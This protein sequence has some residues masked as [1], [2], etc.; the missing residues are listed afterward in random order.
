[1]SIAVIPMSAITDDRLSKTQLRVLLAL[2]SF[3]NPK[4]TNVVFP[5][6]EKLA[7]ITG[8]PVTKISKT[9]SDL[10]KLGWLVKDGNGGRS[11]TT[12]YSLCETVPETVTVTESETVTDLTLNGTRI[13]ILNGTRIGEG[14][15]IDQGIDQNISTGDAKPAR[16]KKVNGQ[17][18]VTQNTPMMARVGSW[19]GRKPETLWTRDEADALRD[20]APDDDELNIVERYYLADHPKDS[21]FR[22]HNVKTMLNNWSGEV[23]KARRYRN[24][25]NNPTHNHDGPPPGA[26]LRQVKIVDGKIVE[27]AGV[28]A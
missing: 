7:Q 13:G 23:D 4:S 1:M 12:R 28:N 24:G 16:R 8:Y 25:G 15:L 3:R 26:K 11:K 5:G 19:F 17:S 20:I 2:Y 21:D 14:L 6:R 9:T 18:R 22:R 10:E 27:E